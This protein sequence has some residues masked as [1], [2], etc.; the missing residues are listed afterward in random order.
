M[1]GRSEIRRQ[2]YEKA[3]K[4]FTAAG[5]LAKQKP[6]VGTPEW[7]RWKRLCDEAIAANAEYMQ[8]LNRD[9]PRVP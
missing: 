3:M 9:P 1:P 8:E 4:A 6:E 2:L 7:E 5:D